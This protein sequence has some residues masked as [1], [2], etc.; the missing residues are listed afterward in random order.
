MKKIPG[1]NEKPE[2]PT[3]IGAILVSM[4]CITPTQLDFVIS[5]QQK[6][7]EDALIGKLCVANGFCNA[8]E[9][10]IAMAT[11][12]ALRLN[13]PTQQALSI[14]NL[15]L[16]RRRRKSIIEQRERI[17]EK[18]EQA[19]KRITGTEHPAITSPLTISATKPQT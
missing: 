9:L 15:A 12:N 17:V 16:N 11:Q 2:Q 6:L 4:G 18:G 8:A 1:Y 7:R 5:E 3:T 13:T 19:V 14:A 10:D